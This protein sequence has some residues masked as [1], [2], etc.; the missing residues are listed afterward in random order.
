MFQAWSQARITLSRWMPQVTRKP[1]LA[2]LET[3]KADDLCH[4]PHIEEFMD[5]RTTL[6]NNFFVMV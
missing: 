4:L 3:D 5:S 6:Y 2:I 1:L